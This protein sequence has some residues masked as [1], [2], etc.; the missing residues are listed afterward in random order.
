MEPITQV[1]QM[2]R[3]HSEFRCIG[4]K[5][6]YVVDVITKPKVRF[7]VLHQGFQV[8]VDPYL[9]L[10]WFFVVRAFAVHCIDPLL[11]WPTP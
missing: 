5:E 1:A 8:D 10:L 9:R 7:D 6:H 2:L 4:T 11:I 3:K